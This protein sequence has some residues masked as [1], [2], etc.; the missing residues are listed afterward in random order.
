MR[1][2]KK[3]GLAPQLRPVRRRL[4]AKAQ[5]RSR[6]IQHTMGE[7]HLEDEVDACVGSGCVAGWAGTNCADVCV[8]GGAVLLSLMRTVMKT[9]TPTMTRGCG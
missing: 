9:T 7:L 3:Q 1:L 8:C 4:M 2:G 5:A 6:S